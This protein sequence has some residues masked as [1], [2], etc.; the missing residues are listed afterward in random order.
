LLRAASQYDAAIALLIPAVSREPRSPELHLT[1]GSA[2]REKGDG[3]R[4]TSHYQA[5]LVASPNYAPALANLADMLSDAGDREA[6][7]TLYDK[8]HQVRSRQRAGPVEPRR[9]ASAERRAEGWL[10]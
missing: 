5:A 6:A 8:A 10:A 9:S 7:R 4:A 3:E 1:L 2:W